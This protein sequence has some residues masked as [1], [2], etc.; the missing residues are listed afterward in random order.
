[1]ITTTLLV[2]QEFQFLQLFYIYHVFKQLVD[3]IAVD[4]TTYG[5]GPREIQNS[6]RDQATE[7][8]PYQCQPCNT[9]FGHRMLLQEHLLSR[10]HELIYKTLKIDF[11]CK[12]QT[13]E[14]NTFSS[15]RLIQDSVTKMSKG[16]IS[17]AFNSAWIQKYF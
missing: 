15:E 16:K 9:T 7:E 11:L 13:M 3:L 10:K 14:I 12:T 5:V 1:M 2:D 17:T 4:S 8:R 6:V